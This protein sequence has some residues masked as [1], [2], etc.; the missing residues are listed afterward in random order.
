[1]LF[2][3]NS[4]IYLDVYQGKPSFIPSKSALAFTG[5]NKLLHENLSS[6]NLVCTNETPFDSY[7]APNENEEHI[8]LNS[9]NMAWVLEELKGNEQP[10]FGY[11]YNNIV[12][13]GDSKLCNGQSATY[14]LNDCTATN[15]NWTTSGNLQVL[16]S[17]NQHIR[18]KNTNTNSSWIRATLPNGQTVFKNI[19]GK[20]SVYYRTEQSSYPRI[21]LY[22]NGVPINQQGIYN[23]QWIKTGGTG[24]IQNTNSFSTYASGYGSNWYVTGQ[25]KVTNSCGTTTKSFYIRPKADPCDDIRFEKFAKN[26]YRIIRPCDDE[27]LRYENVQLTDLYGNTKN[28]PNQNGVINLENTSPKG[29]IRVLKVNSKEKLKSK[30]IIMD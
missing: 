4:S 1:V 20:P 2:A 19:L 3:L 6:R 12:I 8:T 22:G 25:V 10:V 26:Q 16:I 9:K 15:I 7:Y 27:L 13:N 14:T 29:T 21:S 11:N 24:Q 30:M 17:S 28:I 23:T 18:V 5:S